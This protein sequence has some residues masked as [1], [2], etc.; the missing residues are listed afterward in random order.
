MVEYAALVVVA[1]LILGALVA[2]GLPGQLGSHVGTAVCQI[3]QGKD[4]GKDTHPQAAKKKS[5]GQKKDG[6]KKKSGGGCHHFW[7]HAKNGLEHAASAGWNGAKHVVGGAAHAA[8]DQGTGLERL[9]TTNPAKTIK[10]FGIQTWHQTPFGAGIDAYRACS[11]RLYVGCVESGSCALF[12]GACAVE[13]TAA[14]DATKQDVKNG[15]YGDAVGRDLFNV[16]SLFVPT[17]IPGL[18]RVGEIARGAGKAG[19]LAKAAGDAGKAAD[20]AAQLADKGDVA[21]SRRAADEAKRRADDAEKEAKKNGCKTVGLGEPAVRPLVA[22]PRFGRY[23][24]ALPTASGPCN[25]A[26]VA[27]DAA[28]SAKEAADRVARNKGINKALKNGRYEDA[29]N[30]IDEARDAAKK[31]EQ[32]AKDRPTRAN[33]AAAR[34]ARSAA[35]A[36]NKR[37]INQ[38]ITKSLNPGNKKST[39]QEGKV[40]NALRDNL[41]NF[42]KKYGKNGRDGEIDAETEKAIIESA[43]GDS[44]RGKVKQATRNTNNPITN[45]SKKPIIV[46]AP[47]MRYGAVKNLERQTGAKVVRSIPELKQ[48]LR[49]LGESVS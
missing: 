19:D 43:S 48:E 29:D 12:S 22:A 24:A 35:E 30:L 7:C 34:R 13:G 21:G 17:K 44:A 10:A 14:D 6:G 20:R 46:Y 11:K 8:K 15:R 27:R 36:A 25:I 49:S 37:V 18:G 26:Q 23:A 45:P 47:D 39:I 16:G 2:T 42:Q 38:K 9:V 5:G 41:V 1:A 28:G 4:C 3:F 31:A 40:G 32:R 33:R